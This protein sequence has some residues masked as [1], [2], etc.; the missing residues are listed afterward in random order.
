MKSTFVF[1][2]VLLSCA[3][4]SVGLEEHKHEHVVSPDEER[5]IADLIAQ[6]PGHYHPKVDDNYMPRGREYFVQAL[7]MTV[8]DTAPSD[9]GAPTRILIAVYDIFGFHDHIKQIADRVAAGKGNSGQ[10]RVLIPDF[11]RQGP[12]GSWETGTGQDVRDTINYFRQSGA[13]T[14]GIYGFC[15]GGRISVKA[16][17]EIG[18]IRGAGLI[19]PSGVVTDDALTLMGSV[20]LLPASNDPDM[21]S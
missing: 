9:T 21:V 17:Q 12:V 2:V 16:A 5:H 14:F 8:Y 11:F 6:F 1:A 4:F 10:F 18:A 3:C 15:W 19:H 20:L 7:N 13:D